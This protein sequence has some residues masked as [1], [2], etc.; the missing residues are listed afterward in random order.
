MKRYS[1]Y[2][3]AA[4]TLFFF[5]CSGEEEFELSDSIDEEELDL[6][7]EISQEVIDDIINSMPSPVEMT[8]L[9]K[10]TGTKYD[11]SL[12]SSYKNADAYKTDYERAFNM[13]VYGAN[14]GY[15]NIYGK[16]YSS[17]DYV[18]TIRDLSEDLKI[19][20]FFNFKLLKDLSSNSDNIDS[21]IYIT[22]RSFNNMDNY[23][24]EQ[25]RSELSVLMMSGTWLEGLYLSTQVYQKTK[26]E[27][28]RER[29]GEQKINLDN[30]I[31][32]LDAYSADP[33]FNNVY[34]LFMKLKKVY[35]NVEIVQEYKEPV[36]KEVDGR[37]VIID[38]STSEVKM[39][40][41]VIES[42]TSTTKE[43]RASLIK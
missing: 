4:L 33:Y 15:L 23:L 2:F 16:T 30:I 38:N 19:S 27:A 5:N 17:F 42:I 25:K 21:L 35:D 39:S 8:S 31:L 6:S 36:R 18:S 26:D 11:Q 24:R 1:I 43:I 22:T 3:F 32:I 37:L 12:L 7:V 13:G 40:D 41:E 29:I 20:Q 34:S 28:L 9:I 14:L 10:A